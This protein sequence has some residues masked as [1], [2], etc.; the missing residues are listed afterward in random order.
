MALQN[1]MER[2]SKLRH[3]PVYRQQPVRVLWR[4]GAWSVHCLFGIP[5]RPRFARW[6]YRLYLPPKWRGGGCT[7]PYVFRDRYEPE[8]LLLERFLKPGMVFIDGGANTG[9]FTFTAASLVGPTGRVLAFEPGATCFSALR[10]SLALNQWRHVSVFQQALC[11]HCGVARLY[12]HRDQENSFSLGTDETALFDEVAVVSLDEVVKTEVL[13]H[14]D[15]I[16]LDV[17]GAEELVLRGGKEVLQRWR[18]I[19]LFEVNVDATKRLQLKPDGAC[20][21]LEE[22]GYR[23][24][25]SDEHGGLTADVRLSEQVGNLL[26]VPEE[27][28]AGDQMTFHLQSTQH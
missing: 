6:N 18:P 19:V 14:V 21:L 10:E 20:K 13:T 12:H 28:L 5:A 9:V 16:K 26:A 15:F 23:L 4:A 24:F 8:L 17:E 1:L 27:R 25:Q 2:F 22:C 11:D 7:S 3:H